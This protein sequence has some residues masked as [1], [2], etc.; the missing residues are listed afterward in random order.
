MNENIPLNS[1]TA[2]AV[3][4]YD[5]PKMNFIQRVF[6]VIFSPVKTMQSLEQKPRIL[7]ALLLSILTPVVMILSVLPM[8]KEYSRGL[9]EANY[10]KMNVEVTAAQIDQGLNI[11][12]YSGL[13]GGAVVG[14]AM[15]FLGALILWGIV[16]IFKGEG[17]YMQ[18]LS[19]TGYAAVITALSTLVTII[20][21]RLTGTFSLVSFTSLGSILPDMKGNFIYGVAKS[22]EVFSIWKYIVIAIGVATVSKLDKK[23]AYI[24]VL[25]IFAALLIFAGV[26]EVRTAGVI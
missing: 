24:I 13:I 22:L 8:Y 20:T 1:E 9:L 21:T 18:F 2:G 6:G 7:F 5:Y 25:C 15:W 3:A 10:E 4:T 23:K 19:I 17:S 16:K 14:A 11:S 12:T 26:S